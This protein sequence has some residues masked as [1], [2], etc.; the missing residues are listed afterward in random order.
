M[1]KLLTVLLATII[2]LA[3]LGFTDCGGNKKTANDNR[4]PEQVKADRQKGIVR[5]VAASFDVA[6]TGL[7][8]GIVTVRGFRK[9]GEVKPADALK[10]ARTGKRSNAVALKGAQ[11]ILHLDGIDGDAI[12]MIEGLVSAGQELNSEGIIVIKGR[13]QLIFTGITT[14]ALIYLRSQGDELR[15]L[16]GE[17]GNLN[18]K[19]DAN[20]RRKLER[21][22]KT[23]QSNDREFDASISELEQ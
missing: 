2:T 10:M 4:T 13:K 20:S 11:R 18:L 9:G 16:I 7:E 14:G 15:K 23:M 22:V 21:A 17:E 19:L 5:A 6:A 1:R 12:A 3:T 8:S